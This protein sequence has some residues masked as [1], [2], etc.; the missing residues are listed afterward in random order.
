MVSKYALM[1][2]RRTKI[3]VGILGGSFNPPHDGHCYVA[4]QAKKR[5][6]LD[7]VFLLTS[8][9]NPFKS[10]NMRGSLQERFNKTQ[11][12]L[13]FKWHRYGNIR[14]S[15]IEEHFT[16]CYTANTIARLSTLHPETN[17]IWLMGKDNLM[18]IHKW[19]K[20]PKI[21]Q[22]SHVCIIDRDSK[23][24]HSEYGIVLSRYPKRTVSN[25]ITRKRPT[26]GSWSFFKLTKIH[27]SSSALNKKNNR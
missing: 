22:N 24:H 26:K 9:R 2:F 5:L 25:D 3:S 12:L 13:T 11:D 10:G 21:F 20:W 8:P 18:Q 27:L 4:Q 15:K 1:P 7:K 6:A 16:D 23:N 17:F 14:A 19:Y